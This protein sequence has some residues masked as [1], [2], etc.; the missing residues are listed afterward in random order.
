MVS[1]AKRCV[2]KSGIQRHLPHNRPMPGFTL[3]HILFCLKLKLAFYSTC[4]TPV[5]TSAALLLM[6]DLSGLGGGGGTG[7]ITHHEPNSAL[8]SFGDALLTSAVTTNSFN[9]G[10][11]FNDLSGIADK[12]NATGLVSFPSTPAPS[13]SSTIKS[14]MK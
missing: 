6:G 11:S 13:Y 8:P 10:P 2:E 9:H 4:A 12:I 1:L 7:L 3:F 5:P 14:K